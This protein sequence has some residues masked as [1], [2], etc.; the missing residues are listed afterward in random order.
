MGYTPKRTE[1]DQKYERDKAITIFALK[2]FGAVWWSSV[3]FGVFRLPWWWPWG[4]WW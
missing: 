2:V 3:W 4:Q 1:Y